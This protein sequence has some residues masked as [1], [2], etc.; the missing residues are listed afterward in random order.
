MDAVRARTRDEV[1]YLHAEPSRVRSVAIRACVAAFLAA[2]VLVPSLRAHDVPVEFVVEIFA[3][4]QPDGVRVLARVPIALLADVLPVQSEDDPDALALAAAD[5]ATRLDLESAAGPLPPKLPAA[6]LTADRQA[7]DVEVGYALPADGSAI[8]ARLTG[9]RSTKKPVRT[10]AHYRGVDGFTQTVNVTGGED[11][12]TFAPDRWL[13]ASQFGGRALQPLTLTLT[14][15]FLFG[16]TAPKRRSRT[17]IASVIAL[18]IGQAI[19]LAAAAAGYAI[20]S[21]FL[22]TLVI[23]IAGW[24]VVAI[25]IQAIT[26]P[27]TRWTWPIALVFGLTSGIS[28]GADVHTAL[29]LAGGHHVV[30]ALAVIVTLTIGELWILILIRMTTQTVWRALD[31]RA[32]DLAIA[33]AVAVPVVHAGLHAAISTHSV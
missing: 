9:F 16:L 22:P 10:I 19:G 30:A 33:I 28:A 4:T 23:A 25:G 17:L 15:W 8:S 11:R 1:W 18:F 20:A 31:R 5:V 13:V 21:D 29:G 6:R 14:L 26:H 32:P 2:A 3:A 27:S 24:A 7:I 12:V